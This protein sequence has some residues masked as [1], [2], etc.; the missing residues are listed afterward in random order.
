MRNYLF[1]GIAVLL[2]GCAEIRTPTNVG[3]TA[4]TRGYA[5]ITAQ[6]SKEPLDSLLEEARTG[7]VRI[8]VSFGLKTFDSKLEFE[9]EPLLSD[10]EIGMQRRAI[11][12]VGGDI[13]KTLESFDARLV[14]RFELVPVLTLDVGSDALEALIDDPRITK[15]EEDQVAELQLY[16]SVPLIGGDVAH[17]K[18]TGNGRIIAVLDTGV[19]LDHPQLANR[20]VEQACFSRESG[21]LCPN[22]SDEML[23]GNAGQACPSEVAGCE[24]GTQVTGVAAARTNRTAHPPG[25]AP[26]ADIFSIMIAHQEN[27]DCGE[28]P[29]PCVRVARNSY[30]RALEYIL[31]LFH[32]NR[33]LFNRIA[34]VN[35]SIGGGPHSSPCNDSPTSLLMAQ[36]HLRGIASVVASGNDGLNGS[37]LHPACSS[38]A[39]AVGA[40]NKDDSL[41]DYSNHADLISVL[42]PGSLIEAPVLGEPG[43]PLVG[44]GSG[45]S[46]AA[47]HVAATMALLK[48]ASPSKNVIRLTRALTETGK[49]V[50]RNDVCKR[51]I[52]IE[53]A[54]E[55]LGRPIPPENDRFADAHR[56]SDPS[57]TAV[58]TNVNATRQGG[59]GR[60][61][62]HISRPTNSV[63]WTWTAPD[64]GHITVV[65][66][67]SD[68]DTVMTVSTGSSVSSLD[69]KAEDDNGGSGNASKIELEVVSGEAYHIAV[70]GKDR[71]T[72]RIVLS[73][74]FDNSSSGNKGV[75]SIVKQHPDS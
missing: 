62:R 56:M 64:S 73:L 4:S 51:R 23:G 30:N 35:L 43:D 70:D 2:A 50:C 57:W 17:R 18:Y 46:L 16:D 26:D 41:A 22:G 44:F 3:D 52:Q 68:F 29:A 66:N 53:E 25:V 49:N 59:W 19:D 72:G 71:E 40:T 12:E 69:R 20:I 32:D 37:I 31:T 42:A 15:I 6:N 14:T 63:W 67:G 54:L 33:P 27:V 34:V 47:P 7:P 58:G 24:H 10:A 21:T 48:Q 1:W 45:T 55:H 9:L 65:T 39:I 28:V 36:L 38:F 60:G 11:R 8:I 75:A 5:L 13:L 61:E 74:S